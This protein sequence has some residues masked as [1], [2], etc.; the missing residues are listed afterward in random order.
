[1]LRTGEMYG[2]DYP[3]GVLAKKFKRNAM[4]TIRLC[5]GEERETRTHDIM[6]FHYMFASNFRFGSLI[7][8]A[9]SSY[10]TTGIIS[11]N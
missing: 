4:I 9:C 5:V 6:I 3:P 7:L 8:C 1:M 11:A 10:L 2:I